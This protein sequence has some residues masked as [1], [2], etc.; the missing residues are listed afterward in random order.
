MEAFQKSFP[1]VAISLR[2]FPDESSLFAALNSAQKWPDILTIEDSWVSKF[3]KNLIPAPTK[4]LNCD[5]FGRDFFPIAEQNF[6]SKS[7]KLIAVPATARSISMF[8]N[9]ALLRDDRITFGDAPAKTWKDFLGNAKNWREIAE[10]NKYFFA[11]SNEQKVEIFALFLT[12]KK[13]K[14]VAADALQF[15]KFFAAENS[16]FSTAE[17]LLE[18]FKNGE[19][20]VIFG[21]EKTSQ[22]L[23]K[24]FENPPENLLETSLQKKFFH[25]ETVPQ[26]SE[27]QKTFGEISGWA[28]AKNSA[29]SSTAWAIVKFLNARKNL[30]DFFLKSGKVLANKNFVK[31]DDAQNL[32]ISAAGS[33]LL[34]PDFTEIFTENFAEFVAGKKSADEILKVFNKFF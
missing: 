28:V 30:Q 7:G 18:G 21:D 26:F 9:S 25:R 27:N 5:F 8:F 29:E 15:L 23:E 2:E 14:K 12:Q 11:F 13:D 3:E 33:G 24:F 10:E 19:I 4:L 31:K 34:R 20:A 6:C 1:N 32:Q 17:K 22:N 16:K